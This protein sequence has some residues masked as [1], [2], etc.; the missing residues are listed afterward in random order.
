MMLI[1][2]KSYLWLEHLPQHTWGHFSTQ[3]HSSK[4]K[5]SP[6][7]LARGAAPRHDPLLHPGCP[8]PH[9]G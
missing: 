3:E 6:F 7:A 5:K 8:Q 2:L 4:D 1:L 9:A